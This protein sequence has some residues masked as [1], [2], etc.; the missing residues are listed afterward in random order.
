MTKNAQAHK[1]A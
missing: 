1:I